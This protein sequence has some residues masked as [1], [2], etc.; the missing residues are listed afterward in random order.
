MDMSLFSPTPEEQQ[1]IT[2]ELLRGRQR[3]Q[4]AQ[5]QSTVY[6]PAAAAMQMANNP[7]AANAVKMFDVAQQ[8]R[9]TPQKLGTQ[10]MVIPGT[11]EFIASPMFVQDKLESRA[12]QRGMAKERALQQATLAQERQAASAREGEANRT[13]RWAIAQLNAGK[14]STSAELKL[15]RDRDTSL[16]KYSASLEKAGVP[17]FGEA[18]NIVEGT[19]AGFKNGELPGFGRVEGLVPDWAASNKMQ[20]VRSSMQQAANIL[21][22]SRSGAAVTESEMRRFLTEVAQGKGMDES[23]LRRGWARVRQTF[24]EKVRNLTTS[25]PPEL[26]DE[27]VARGGVD[28]R[29]VGKNA[30]GNPKPAA[31][32]APEGVDQK[33]WDVMT[34]EERKLWQN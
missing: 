31:S 1:R 24:N 26:H 25:I 30:P 21:L 2:A 29:E 13:L 12:Q 23:T 7:G 11:G 18:L 14:T 16:Q 6:A 5:E 19:L 20:D 9:Y 33:L 17:E 8:E 32:K 22:K 34:P 28:Y 27:Y 3:L 4:Q 10:G 15:G